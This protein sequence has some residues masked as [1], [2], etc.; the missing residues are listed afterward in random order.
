MVITSIPMAR[1][2]VDLAALEE[3][4]ARHGRPEIFSTDQGSQVTSTACIRTCALTHGRRTVPISTTCRSL[5]QREFRHRCR[6]IAPVGLRPPCAIRR[7]QHTINQIGRGS[8]Y[9]GQTL[10]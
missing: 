2:F 6:G 7:Q 4:L 3:A 1:V 9:R 8:T 5:G 10:S